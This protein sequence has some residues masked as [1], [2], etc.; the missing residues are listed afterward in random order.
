VGGVPIVARIIAAL[1][2]LV[3]EHMVLT[4]DASLA[5]VALDLRLVYDPEPHAG[6]LPALG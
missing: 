6:V 2:P 3:D 1:G 4:N 5:S